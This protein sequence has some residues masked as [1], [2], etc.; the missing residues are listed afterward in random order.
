MDINLK[1]KGIDQIDVEGIKKELESQIVS[2]TEKHGNIIGSDEY[3]RGIK[4]TSGDRVAWK[5]KIDKY[6]RIS[7]FEDKGE[8]QELF[9]Y[10]STP[11]FKES[12]TYTPLSDK[13]LKITKH[14]LDGNELYE[15]LQYYKYGK[16][17]EFTRYEDGMQKRYER[18]DEKEVWEEWDKNGKVILRQERNIKLGD[19]KHFED[20]IPKQEKKTI[21]DNR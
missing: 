14:D 10:K 16:Y 3:G 7:L 4:F 18:S 6:T 20:I 12:F 9:I 15:H 2:E 19:F 13:R 8:L 21:I 11:E 5:G 17:H 1:V